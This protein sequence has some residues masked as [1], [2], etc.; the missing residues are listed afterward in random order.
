MNSSP[1]SL[2]RFIRRVYRRLVLLRL[3]EWA[4]VGFALGCALALL[5]IVLVRNRPESPMAIAAVL[6]GVGVAIGF[7]A[8]LLRRPRIIDAAVE[9]DRQLNLADL[10]AT[11][12]QL[13]KSPAIESFEE[14]VLLIANQRAGNLQPQSVVLHRLGLRAWSGIGLAGALVLTVAIFSANPIDSEA[15]SSPFL[16][17]PTADKEKSSQNSSAN[18]GSRTKRPPTIAPDQ[19][20]SDNEAPPRP[21]K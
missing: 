5:S 17:Q 15:S 11:A 21:G 9:A 1:T 8:A 7:I 4:G 18:S 12:W 3:A 10:L 20:T 19:P 2:D 14:A 13:E 16:Q 6:T